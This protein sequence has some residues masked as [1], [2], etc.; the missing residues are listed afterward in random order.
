MSREEQGQGVTVGLR[1]HRLHVS[2]CCYLLW[3]KKKRKNIV[4][5]SLFHF[6]GSVTCIVS[7]NP[8]NHPVQQH[9]PFIDAGMR[10]EEI[11]IDLRSILTR[12]VWCQNPHSS[13][14]RPTPWGW[15]G[16]FCSR[17]PSPVFS[18]ELEGRF[19]SFL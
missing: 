5:E 4:S 12:C 11:S 3:P 13:F 18:M 8:H 16:T 10:L 15:L 19:L 2:F 7:C 17:L 14:A 6:H 1:D 9:Y